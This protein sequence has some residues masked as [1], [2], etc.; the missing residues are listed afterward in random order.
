MVMRYVLLIGDYAHQIN[1]ILLKVERK[2]KD[3][4]C[5][6]ERHASPVRYAKHA[7]HERMNVNGRGDQ[8]LGETKRPSK[9]NKY[10]KK[11]KE[12]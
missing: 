4:K 10:T 6:C 9:I 12:K 7:R 3:V 11:R 2:I 8:S 1:H 5:Q